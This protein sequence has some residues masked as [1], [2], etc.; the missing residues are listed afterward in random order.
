MNNHIP[1]PKPES[2]PRVFDIRFKLHEAITE[3]IL[4]K[5]REFEH[6]LNPAL[7]V[8]LL[9]TLTDVVLRGV[10]KFID[11]DV[12]HGGDFL[13]DLDHLSEAFNEQL[14]SL[15]YRAAAVLIIHKHDDRYK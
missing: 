10:H 2:D 7:K 11:G 14:D 9:N 12:R 6:E 4:H 3:L 15:F 1:I 5:E 8:F 13:N